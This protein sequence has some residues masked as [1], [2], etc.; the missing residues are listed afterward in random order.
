MSLLWRLLTRRPRGAEGGD[1]ELPADL[2]PDPEPDIE[3]EAEEEAL[4]PLAPVLHLTDAD[5]SRAAAALDVEVA[6]VRAVAEVEAAGCGFLP[7][8]R[9]QILYEAHIFDRQ[10][11]GRHRQ[12]RDSNG[13][14]LSVPNWDRTLYGRAG[15]HQH[16]VRLAGAARLDWD[17][18]HRA[19][20]WGL[21]QILG[22]NHAAVGHPTIRG[23]VEAMHSGAGP[24][25]DAF[26]GFV[27]A[28]RLD[29]HLRTRNWQAFARGYNGPGFAANRYDQKLAAAYR[30]WQGKG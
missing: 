9:P 19:C 23:F 21:F 3:T 1:A 6:A 29:G 27:R 25:L 5:F 22:T 7:D 13:V 14:R 28:T 18:A 8:G 30:R 26:V 20:S 12:A 4:P 15:A 24:H 17:A 16:D 2:G 10:T 11:S